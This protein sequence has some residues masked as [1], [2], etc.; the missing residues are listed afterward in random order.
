MMR[1][2]FHKRMFTSHST[3]RAGNGFTGKAR[4]K[5]AFT[6][7]EVTLAMGILVLL[8]GALYA[9]VDA[10]VTGTSELEARENRLQEEGGILALLRKTFKAMPA[11]ALFEA[12]MVPQGGKFFPELLFRN[13]PG[14][15]KQGDGINTP[16]ATILG[17]QQQVGGLVNLGMLQDSADGINSYWG[18][19]TARHSWLVLMPGLRE[20]Q[21]RFYDPRTRIWTGDWKEPAFHPL[22]AELSLTTEEGTGRYVFWIPPLQNL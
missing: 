16:V 15:F 13:C 1:R 2:K 20:V 18:G 14:F 19:G 12:R 6:L 10:S 7:L 17:V 5:E 11:T 21:W 3:P 22:F 4:R 8:A 9:M